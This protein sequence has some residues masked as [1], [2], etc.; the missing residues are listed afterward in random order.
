MNW[1]QLFYYDPTSPSFLRN[2]TTRS[3]RQK[4][5]QV[6]GGLSGPQDSKRYL[7]QVNGERVYNYRIIWE[8]FNGPI[9][10]GFVIDH[11]DRNPL[12]C[13]IENLRICQQQKNVLNKQVKSRD[14]PR[15][16][17]KNK[18]GTYYA[19]ITYNGQTFNLGTRNTPEEQGQLYQHKQAELFGEYN[20]L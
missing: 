5:D 13:Q 17:Y 9:P 10:E 20:P 4:L 14:L 7:V 18:S 12:N 2:Q 8:L 6:S 15:G 19:Q 11:K 16:V 1:H 3:N